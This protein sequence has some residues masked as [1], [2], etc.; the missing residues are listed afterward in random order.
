MVEFLE[1]RLEFLS[2]PATDIVKQ[3]MLDRG[4]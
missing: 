1:I 2:V 3:C 4:G